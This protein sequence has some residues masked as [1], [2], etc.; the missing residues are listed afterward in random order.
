MIKPLNDYVLLEVEEKEKKIGKII[1]TASEDKKTNTAR[2]VAMGLGKLV[3]NKR[4]PIFLNV[5]DEV[6]YKDYSS[7]EYTENNKK[8]LLVQ[9]EDIVAVVE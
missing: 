2:V 5:G 9:E 6:I 1:I 8:Y 7:L 3:D 4:V